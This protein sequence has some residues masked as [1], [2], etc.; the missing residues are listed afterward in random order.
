MHALFSKAHF[1]QALYRRL[2]IIVTFQ[3]FEHPVMSIAVPLL[4]L[5]AGGKHFE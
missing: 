2:G 1:Y 5:A 4:E 3:Q